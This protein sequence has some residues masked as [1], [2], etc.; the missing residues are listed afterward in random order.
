MAAGCRGRKGKAGKQASGGKQAQASRLGIRASTRYYANGT[1][2]A[3]LGLA[4][5]PA[6]ARLC[7]AVSPSVGFSM[8]LRRPRRSTVTRLSFCFCPTRTTRHATPRRA[9]PCRAARAPR[10]TAPYRAAPIEPML[11]SAS[12]RS[13]LFFRALSVS[14]FRSSPV[15]VIFFSLFLP[16]YFFSLPQARYRPFGP[17]RRTSALFRRD[18]LIPRSLRS[19]IVIKSFLVSSCTRLGAIN[20]SLQGTSAPGW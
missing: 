12:A 4:R 17:F 18:P 11:S 5:A 15:G 13:S 16:R 8:P 6:L 20:V 2:S 14:L 10:H 9:A 3:R 19:A 1:A 7:P